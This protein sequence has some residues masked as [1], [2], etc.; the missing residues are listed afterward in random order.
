MDYDFNKP[1]LEILELLR[2]CLKNE[3]ELKNVKNY[4]IEN[5]MGFLYQSLCKKGILP[6]E[7]KYYKNIVEKNK[8]EIK[9]IETEQNED[10]IRNIEREKLVYMSKVGYLD[11]II[12]E[13]QKIEMNTSFKMD[14]LLCEIRLGLILREYNL[15]QKRINTGL[16]YIEKDCDW[17]RK[18]K[19]KVYYGLYNLL[20]RNFKAAGD[21]FASSLAT[22][23]CTELF[24]YD[25]IVNYSIFCALL[26]FDRNSLEEKILKSTDV[27]EVKDKCTKAYKLAQ[28]IHNCYYDRI[29]QD[30]IEFCDEFLDDL[31]IGDKIS[32]F[33]QEIKIRVYNQLL[34]SYSSIKLES[35][36]TAF[37]V[38]V[39]FLEKDLNQFLVNER[40]KCM[41]DKVDNMVLVRECER[42]YVDKI[43]D[44]CDY[45]MNYVEKQVN[46]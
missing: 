9:D 22:F 40:I 10:K 23:Q 6:D 16:K 15:V 43:G 38:T 4:L 45:I 14:V 20:N 42:S 2:K 8:N 7:E 24:S 46:K 18:N 17:D 35:M 33:L 19:F 3:K 44:S 13:G 31:F 32:F 30:L 21:L 27:I 12:E 34:E 36:A 39:D 28:N 41:I 37:K 29:F 26:S 25:K 11:G 1:S 5:K